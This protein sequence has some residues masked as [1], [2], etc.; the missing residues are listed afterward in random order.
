LIDPNGSRIVV[1]HPQIDS[2]ESQRP[3]RNHQHFGH[4]FSANPL[5]P[6]A[7]VTY[8]DPQFRLAGPPGDMFQFDVADE[9]LLVINDSER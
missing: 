8:R 3:K 5:I 4:R 2:L 6:I 1:P 9:F 7:L